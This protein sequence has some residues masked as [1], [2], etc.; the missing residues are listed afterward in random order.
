[1]GEFELGHGAVETTEG[2]FDFA[3]VADFFPEAHIAIRD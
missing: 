2:A 1:V 3:E